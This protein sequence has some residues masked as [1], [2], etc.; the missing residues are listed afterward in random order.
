MFKSHT[1]SQD[2]AQLTPALF[3]VRLEYFAIPTQYQLLSIQTVF[4]RSRAT[5]FRAGTCMSP[6]KT[7]GV[8][9]FLEKLG[10]Q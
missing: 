8:T 4:N 2:P 1:L 10:R 5:L 3:K 9:D 7:L 6:L